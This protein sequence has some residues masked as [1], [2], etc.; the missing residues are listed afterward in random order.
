MYFDVSGMLRIRYICDL[1]P[2]ELS[3]CVRSLLYKLNQNTTA[4]VAVGIIGWLQSITRVLFNS[5]FMR[6]VL[7][8][9]DV[10]CVGSE[11][12]DDKYSFVVHVIRIL[13]TRN[14]MLNDNEYNE[15]PTEGIGHI[16]S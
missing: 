5:I 4:A 16:V 7:F 1:S 3:A 12:N 11:I 13:V 2:C 9:Q 14:M 8:L 15:W 10:L 6:H